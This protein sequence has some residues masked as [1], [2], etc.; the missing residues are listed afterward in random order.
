LIAGARSEV[1]QC[2]PVARRSGGAEVLGDARLR[3]HAA[4][5]DQHDMLE[6]E[7]LLELGN[8]GGERLRIGGVAVEHLDRDRASVRRAEQAIDDLQGSRAAIAAVAP[9]GQRTATP[10]H[11]G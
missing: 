4:I 7:P 2:S 1:I 8:L 10:L 11:V 6:P 5:A 3:D 9:P